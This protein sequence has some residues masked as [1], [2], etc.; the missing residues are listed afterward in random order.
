VR[1]AEWLADRAED[2]ARADLEPRRA[3]L[4]ADIDAADFAWLRR[5][6]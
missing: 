2:P 1:R 4:I 5:G 3:A 6:L